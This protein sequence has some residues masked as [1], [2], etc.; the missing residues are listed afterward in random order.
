MFTH[1]SSL[2]FF[3]FVVFW[4]FAKTPLAPTVLTGEVVYLLGW[5]GIDGMDG[6][7]ESE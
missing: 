2:S 5:D 3:F 1:I 7:R 6:W 4:S